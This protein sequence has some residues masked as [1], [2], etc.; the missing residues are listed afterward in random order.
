MDFFDSLLNQGA[1]LLESLAGDAFTHNGESF[2]G[3]FRTGNSLEQADAAQ[4]MGSHGFQMKIVVI[5]HV[6]RS[7]FTAP[8]ISWRRQKLQRL[9]PTPQEFTILSVNTDDP[10]V[11]AFVLVG[12]Q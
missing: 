4:V 10:N 12:I 8:P 11:Y 3:N 6:T 9:T 5:L 2:V 1:A 7:Q